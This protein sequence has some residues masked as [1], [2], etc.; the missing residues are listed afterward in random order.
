MSS[1]SIVFRNGATVRGMRWEPG[2]GGGPS[3]MKSIRSD[4]CSPLGATAARAWSRD[5]EVARVEVGVELDT[6]LPGRMNL[7]ESSV[8]SEGRR[9]EF[10]AEAGL[11][12]ASTVLAGLVGPGGPAGP[13]D[14]MK[15]AKSRVESTAGFAFR[16]RPV[17][18][19]DRG[20]GG[21]LVS[22]MGWYL[23]TLALGED[24]TGEALGEEATGEAL[25]EEATEE[26]LGE[27]AM[28]EALGAVIRG[29]SSPG[30][31]VVFK[32][33]ARS[34]VLERLAFQRGESGC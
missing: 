27:E 26:A 3:R 9:A 25:G 18:I 15:S 2:V 5:P 14:L 30:G 10:D 33:A 13:V 11:L 12:G 32:K 22:L 16:A 28:G 7:F 17:A 20:T 1:E 29:L 6:L 4:V 21:N 8:A 31:A 34:A 19:F 24:A 23:G